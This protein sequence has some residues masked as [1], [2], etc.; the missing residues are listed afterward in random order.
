MAGVLSS[1]IT[2]GK[3]T[4]LIK[5][6]SFSVESALRELPVKYQSVWLRKLSF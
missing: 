4:E 5:L 2:S 1:F 6:G 3:G